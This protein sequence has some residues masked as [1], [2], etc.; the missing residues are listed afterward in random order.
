[1]EKFNSSIDY[2]EIRINV[3][4]HIKAYIYS[5]MSDL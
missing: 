4:V 3:Y 1:M 2:V 5:F